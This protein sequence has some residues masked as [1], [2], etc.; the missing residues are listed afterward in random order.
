MK[1]RRAYEG[2]DRSEKI[3]KLMKKTGRT[4]FGA[5]LWTKQED[6][7]II[8]HYPK[9]PILRKLL[10]GR[11]VGAIKARASYLKVTKTHKLWTSAKVSLLRRMCIGSSWQNILEEF[12][13]FSSVQIRCCMKLHGI[14]RIKPKY[15]S[16]KWPILND[17]RDKAYEQ[18]M[19]MADLDYLAGTKKY[20]QQAQWSCGNKP[21]PVAVAKAVLL[22]G[23]ELHVKWL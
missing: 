14:K 19:S 9:L 2:I 5:K 4:P 17:I 16:T 15:K 13:D 7:K 3:R 12:S 1:L 11:T 22:L 6:A 21:N 20:F 23:G 10:K 18:N 8:E